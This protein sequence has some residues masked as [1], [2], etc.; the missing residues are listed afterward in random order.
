MLLAAHAGSPVVR[1]WALVYFQG[2]KEDQLCRQGSVR[3]TTECSTGDMALDV[4]E[5]T[6]CLATAVAED[7]ANR[8]YTPPRL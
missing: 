4:A 1:A 7:D 8:I 5:G 6:R 2:R 3:M